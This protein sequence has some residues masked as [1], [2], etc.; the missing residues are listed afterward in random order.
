MLQKKQLIT[1]CRWRRQK[2]KSGVKKSDYLTKNCALNVVKQE[3]PRN[4][5]HRKYGVR[6]KTTQRH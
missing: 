4:M 6:N 2:L 3:V 5:I 1:P